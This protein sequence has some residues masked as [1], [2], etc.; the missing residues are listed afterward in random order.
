MIVTFNW[1]HSFIHNTN[2]QCRPLRANLRL[3]TSK[4][5]EYC[6][7]NLQ[8][9]RYKQLTTMTNKHT[10]TLIVNSFSLTIAASVM[11]LKLLVHNATSIDLKITRDVKNIQIKLML[12]NKT[13]S[14]T[15]VELYEHKVVCGRKSTEVASCTSSLSP[16]S[17]NHAWKWLGCSIYNER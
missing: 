11:V 10:H 2:A 5:D 1:N 8:F 16:T 13:N 9:Q 14:T 15:T 4:S 6:G 17:Q 3:M 7:I 12:H